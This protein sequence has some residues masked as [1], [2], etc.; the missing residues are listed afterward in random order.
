M[1]M[2]RLLEQDWLIH[3]R[4]DSEIVV[5]FSGAQLLD[6]S[7]R[8][9]EG[10]VGGAKYGWGLAGSCLSSLLSVF[11]PSEMPSTFL[12]NFSACGPFT[13]VSRMR[14]MPAIHSFA[15]VSV[16]CYRCLSFDLITWA[17]VHQH[18]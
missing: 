7:Y 15:H 12:C 14:W 8:G 1:R 5:Y 9:G 11:A 10:A 6:Q 4:G 2:G 16:V 17:P 13:Y 18:L 3:H